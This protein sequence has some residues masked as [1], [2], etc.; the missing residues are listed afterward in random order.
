MQYSVAFDEKGM[1]IVEEGGR[2][3]NEKTD[4][5]QKELIYFF[6]RFFF[7]CLILESLVGFS[8]KKGLIVR[9]GPKLHISRSIYTIL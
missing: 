5:E 6:L 2:K 7:F 9:R 3:Q 1:L 4:M 8:I